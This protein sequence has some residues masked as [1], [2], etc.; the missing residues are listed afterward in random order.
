MNSLSTG[1]ISDDS[2]NPFRLGDE[3]T[4]D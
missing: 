3:P 2:E 4:G 1:S